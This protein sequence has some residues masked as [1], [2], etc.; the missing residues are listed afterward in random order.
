MARDGSGSRRGLR[1]EAMATNF[2]VNGKAA[3]T[4]APPEGDP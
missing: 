1:E 3:S 4:N 2:T